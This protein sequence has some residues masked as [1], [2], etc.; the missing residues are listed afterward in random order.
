MF[1][2]SSILSASSNNFLCTTVTTFMA[3]RGKKMSFRQSVIAYDCRRWRLSRGRQSSKHSVQ[4]RFLFLIS[5]RIYQHAHGRD[6]YFSAIKEL[7]D[8]IF[9]GGKHLR[10]KMM[11]QIKL[12]VLCEGIKGIGCGKSEEINRI[13]WNTHRQN[14]RCTWGGMV[15]PESYFS[16]LF[17]AYWLSVNQTA[18]S[19][20]WGSGEYKG[21]SPSPV[22]SRSKGGQP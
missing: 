12:D 1:W 3:S 11:S 15:W 6:L 20:S 17:I 4:W 9:M 2:L 10:M 21:R 16:R 5:Y 13:W 8:L 19:I 18:T 14:K 7:F 22:F